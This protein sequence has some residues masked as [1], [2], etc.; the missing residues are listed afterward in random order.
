MLAAGLMN[1]VG[2]PGDLKWSLAIPGGCSSSPPAL[3]TNGDILIGT[4][5]KLYAITPSGAVRWDFAPMQTVEVAGPTVATDGTIYFGADKLYALNPDGSKRWEFEYYENTGGYTA[6]IGSPVLGPDGAIYVTRVASN[7]PQRLFALEPDRSLR[8]TFTGN[9]SGPVVLGEDGTILISHGARLSAINPDGVERWSTWLTNGVENSATP[10]P[11]GGALVPVT[12]PSILNGAIHA[13]TSSGATAW[14]FEGNSGIDGTPVVGPDGVIYAAFNSGRVV[15]LTNGFLKWEYHMENL[16][17]TYPVVLSPALA[18]DGTLYA[19]SER[20]LYAL[21]SNGQLLWRFDTGLTE[22]TAPVIAEDGTI[23]FA[24]KSV[25][26]TIFA[27]EGTGAG[28]ANSPWPMG[29]RNARHQASL[30]ETQTI[31]SMPTDFFGD[32]FTDRVELGW[33]STLHATHFQILRSPTPNFA[34]AVVI[35]NGLSGGRKYSDRTSIPGQM[36]YYFVRAVNAAGMS[37]PAGPI[38]RSRPIAA[39]GEAAWIFPTG[40]TIENPAAF[41]HD[42]TAYFG[43]RDGNLYAVDAAGQL[44][45]SFNFGGR[46]C[47]SP[48]VGANGT[49]YF[50]AGTTRYPT[51]ETNALFAI[52]SSGQ[53]LWRILIPAGEPRNSPAIGADGTLYFP[54][55]TGLQA[56]SATGSNIWTLDNGLGFCATP[57]IGAEGTIYALV[58]GGYIV[59]IASNGT[60]LWKTES[61]GAYKTPVIGDN[62]VL[63]TAGDDYYA[64]NPDGQ[65]LWTLDLSLWSESGPSLLTPQGMVY[66]QGDN[67]HLRFDTNG[68]NLQKFILPNQDSSWNRVVADANGT[69]YVSG[70]ITPQATVYAMSPA[71]VELWAYRI[72]NNTFGSPTL[73]TNHLLLVPAG[74]ELHALRTSAG[75]GTSAWPHPFHDPQHTGRATQAPPLPAAPVANAT[76]RT[77]ITD[78]QVS[79]NS[80]LAASS[81]EVLRSTTT[82]PADAV[83]LGPVIGR[84]S[85]DDKSA[86][87]E[88]D[89]FYWVKAKNMTGSGDFST[90]IAG[91]RRQAVPGELLYRWTLGTPMNSSPAIAANGTI[92]ATGGSKLAALNPDGS[93]KWEHPIPS[94]GLSSPAIGSNGTIYVGVQTSQ[95]QGLSPSPL[96]AL[97][98]DGSELWRFTASNNIRST[99]AIGAD[100]MI[101]FTIDSI[102]SNRP[103]LLYAL[104]PQGQLNWMLPL[105]RVTDASIAIARNGMLYVFTRDGRL[106]AVTPNGVELWNVAAGTAPAGETVRPAPAIGADGTIHVSG[107]S[108][109]A[110]HPDGQLRW[111]T[112]NGTFYS[113]P[114]IAADGSVLASAQEGWTHLVRDGTNVWR[115]QTSTANRGAGTFAGPNLI[116]AAGSSGH[117]M[118]LNLSGSNVWQLPVGSVGVA[119]PTI[120]PDGTIYVTTSQGDV[121]SV[122]GTAPL[123]ESPWPMFQHDVRHTGRNTSPPIPPSFLAHPANVPIRQGAPLNLTAEVTG[124]PWPAFQWYWNNTPVP[125]ATNRNLSF[126]SID[127]SEAGTYRVVASNEADSV[128]SSNAFVT[129]LP[130]NPIPAGVVAWWPGESN[131]L[132][133]ASVNSLALAGPSGQTLSPN[134]FIT[135][136]SGSAIQLTNGYLRAA[137]AEEL[138]LGAGPGFT[139]E[140]WINPDSVASTQPLFEW[141]D[142][143]WIGAGLTIQPYPGTGTIGLDAWFASTNS[144]PYN[145]SRSVRLQLREV[146][147]VSNAWQHVALTYDRTVGVARVYVGGVA[148]GQTNLGAFQPRTATPFYVGYRPAGNFSG[149]YYRGGLDEFTLYNRALSPAELQAIVTADAGGKCLPPPACAPLVFNL[150][151]WWRGESNA[152]DQ[153]DGNHGVIT[154]TISFTNGMVGRAFQFSTGVIKV[155]ANSNLDVGLRGGITIEG[156]VKTAVTGLQPLV[157]WNSG[158]GTQGVALATASTLALQANLTDA[159]GVAHVFNSPQRILT[160]GMWQHIA[161][162]YDQASGMAVLYREGLKVAQA[163]LGS[164]VL[165]TSH[166]LFL[167][168]R[169]V[170]GYAGSGTKYTGAMDEM[171]IYSRAL[172]PTEIRTIVKARG[173]GKCLDGPV[174]VR[175]TQVEL[176]LNGRSRPHIAATSPLDLRVE[177]STNLIHWQNIGVPQPVGG[178]EFEFEDIQSAA[179]PARYYRLVSP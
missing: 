103:G 1:T 83:L 175:F 65:R 166:D 11:G 14:H 162:T 112:T 90:P 87:P 165:R 110:F 100:G 12:G 153:I 101:Y 164:F 27:V 19:T 8:W 29:R 137:Q 157:E 58:G 174:L 33:D 21:N 96:L 5:D 47:K 146:G 113:S 85:Y 39:V 104:S 136:K 118:A 107:G 56:I 95:T 141:N 30:A 24:A 124:Y 132:D 160:N 26:N 102:D 155:A 4:C 156:W 28:L 127:S 143:I 45:W 171:G 60:I 61:G 99:P 148:V 40:D 15:A 161:L 115:Y 173:K 108:L 38:G 119:S 117:L 78:V 169:P 116:Y 62:G 97:N 52:N 36:N 20:W 120:A 170:G 144:N 66:G 64:F 81:Y 69:L 142:G 54:W 48:A 75:L 121:V 106:H 151:G 145:P 126:A 128:S 42:G 154:Q 158:T 74:N 9:F 152:F 44:K 159:N 7:N 68:N 131:L 125:G 138:D 93:V 2:A 92:Y 71:G 172:T 167:G 55:C 105:S 6:F 41:G 133:N 149:F 46:S 94:L 82:N 129:V 122:Y 13:L 59:A 67:T 177:A 178:G 16:T 50:S 63:F 89:Y 17:N 168:Y 25:T 176:Q 84:L 23:Y 37:A 140:G 147:I 134:P 32:G 22:L 179:T 130:C 43:S 73:G 98:P 18:A 88:T 57:V 111:Q 79:W 35:T 114:V 135:G 150:V 77:R 91:V 80:V 139:V 163:N 123:A 31:P 49:V 3:A 53:L 70:R 72:F 34:N 10:L 51:P 76:V 86:I 109:K